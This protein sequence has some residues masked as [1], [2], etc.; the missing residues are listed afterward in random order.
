M[1]LTTG[2]GPFSS[3]PIGALNFTVAP[4]TG[5]AL[6]WWPVSQRI[7]A[8][9]GGETVV[10]SRQAKLLHETGHLPV[11]YFPRE[12]VRVDLL[13]PSDHETFCPHKGRAS[14]WTIAV[15]ERTVRDAMWEYRE[16]LDAA[17]FLTGHVALYW[18][19]VDEWFAED[20]LLLGHPRDPFHRIDV[21]PTSRHVRVLLDGEV[22]A[23]SVRARGLFETALPPRWYLPAEDVRADLL[24]AS[25]TKTRCAYKGSASY[26]SV[27]VGDRFEDDLVWSYLEP[28]HDAEQVGGLLCF[29]NER[30]D[31]ELDGEPVE[32]PRTQWSRD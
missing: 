26:W 19:R 1:G 10:D 17:S 20:E 5:S 15:G 8:I 24:E 12:E 7:R 25:A 28:E 31:L 14:Y 22:L 6:I 27:R 16:P 11:Y 4:A 18:N 32:R 2:V 21:H 29:F 30:V 9:V 23:E 3:S 13:E